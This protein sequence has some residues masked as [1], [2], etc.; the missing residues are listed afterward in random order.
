MK[1]ETKQPSPEEYIKEKLI[2]GNEYPIVRGSVTMVK[3][4]PDTINV[5]DAQEAVRLARLEGEEKIKEIRESIL[6]MMYNWP[7]TQRQRDYNQAIGVVMEIIDKHLN[8][9]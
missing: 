1:E 8:Q 7:Y 3:T 9:K 4:T 6:K 2:P 5:V